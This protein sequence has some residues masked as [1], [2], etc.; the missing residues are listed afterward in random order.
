MRLKK[1]YLSKNHFQ[2][3]QLILTFEQWKISSY[4]HASTVRK[5]LTLLLDNLTLPILWNML[6]TKV[7]WLKPYYSVDQEVLVKQ[8]VPES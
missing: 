4:P 8:L 3:S 2:N 6:L 7:S 1:K 5:S